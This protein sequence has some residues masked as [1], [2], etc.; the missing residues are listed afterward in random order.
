MPK[1]DDKVTTAAL[2]IG[3]LVRY[4]DEGWRTGSLESV[5]GKIARIRPLAGFRAEPKRCVKSP[6]GDVYA[7]DF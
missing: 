4:Y 1:A 3:S 5:K 7:K 2:P 6:I